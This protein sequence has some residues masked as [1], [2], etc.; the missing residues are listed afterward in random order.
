MANLFTPVFIGGTGRSGTTILLNLLSRHPEF[1]ASMPREIKYLTSR[2]GL[3]DLVFTRP[4]RFEETLKSR[5]NN[6]AARALPLFGRCQIDSFKS[7]IFGT[8][9]SEKGKKGTTRGLVQGI[10]REILEREFE[11][12]RAQYRKDRKGAARQLFESLS[13]AQMQDKPKRY[14]GDST[15]VNMM[16]SDLIFDLLPTSKFINVIRDGRDVASSVVKEKWGPKSHREALKWWENRISQAHSSLSTIPKD[17]VLEVRI[18]DLV[19]HNRESA[20]QRILAFLN[21][22][23]NNRLEKYFADELIPERLHAGRWKTEVANP[24]KFEESYLQ[25][26]NRLDSKGIF[27][28]Q[29]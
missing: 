9:W 15:P 29:F 22:E 14:F 5:R 12:F 11:V 28:K 18:E 3:I 20:L 19:V 26:L 23:P 7:E 4:M 25:I 24:E 10:P 13:V 16:Q 1:H 27:V 21:L 2:H 8:W 6:L 17:H